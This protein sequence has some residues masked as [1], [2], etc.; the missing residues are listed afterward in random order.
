MTE[1]KI[2]KPFEF[3][4]NGIDIEE[5]LYRVKYLDKQTGYPFCEKFCKKLNQWRD[6]GWFWP[7]VVRKYQGV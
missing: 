6:N 2:G 5:G 4:G 7:D 3:D 1:I